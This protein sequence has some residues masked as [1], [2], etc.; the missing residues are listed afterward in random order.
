M[1]TD[2]VLDVDNGRRLVLQGEEVTVDGVLNV[3]GGFSVAGGLNLKA[4]DRLPSSANP[5][6]VVLVVKEQQGFGGMF[7]TETKLWLCVLP[8]SPSVEGVTYWREIQLGPVV[9]GE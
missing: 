3:A 4:V 1:A 2:I 5:G 7:F 9:S 8:E 6:D